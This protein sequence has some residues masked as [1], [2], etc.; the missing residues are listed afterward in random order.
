MKAEFISAHA[1]NYTVGRTAAID[2]IVIHYTAGDGDTAENNGKYFQGADRNASCHYFVDED[3]VVMS[4]REG[5]TAWHAGN[6]NMNCRSIGIEM[7]S[8]KDVTGKYY[9]SNGTIEN[10]LKL[11]RD[12]MGR[13]GI[14]VA[15]V[16]RHYDVTGKKCPEPFVR[17][18]ALWESFRK[19][20]TL[21]NAHAAARNLVKAK[22]GL[23]DE[24]MNYLSAYRWG[25]DL[26]RKLA[27]AMK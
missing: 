26:L 12:L 1:S 8:Y 23:S 16:V 13:Y 5:D 4:V 25:E 18:P 15:G 11:T 6:W 9:I 2:R 27:A 19:E 17:D 3:S 10:T 24:T 14:P 20:L 21:S 22:A 7:C